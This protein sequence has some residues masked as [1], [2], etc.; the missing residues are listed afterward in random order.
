M[1]STEKNGQGWVV[2]FELRV[3]SFEQFQGAAVYR[4]SLVVL[5]GNLRQREHWAGWHE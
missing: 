1:V 4:G 3:G 5:G 2:E